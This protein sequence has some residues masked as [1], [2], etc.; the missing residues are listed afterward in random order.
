[1]TDGSKFQRVREVL[2]QAT[3]KAHE[4]LHG[5]EAFV[6]IAQ[7]RLERP[8]YAALLNRLATFHLS[9]APAA[10]G[11]GAR[12][13]MLAQDLRVFGMPVPEPLPWDLPDSRPARLG[14]KYVVEG[15][16][17]GGRVIH[18]QLDYLFG[19]EEG[20]RR[21]FGA[22]LKRAEWQ[23]LCSDLETG[24]ADQRS[25]EE[26]TAGAAAAFEQFEKVVCG[27]GH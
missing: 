25:L 18:R 16:A 15:S 11:D 2:R 13:E 20:G 7:G 9:A 10:Q 6:A 5:A 26:M 1:M 24:G 21:F 17:F 19:L 14:W 12:L 22:G 27:E 8:D 4:R 3:G 23:R